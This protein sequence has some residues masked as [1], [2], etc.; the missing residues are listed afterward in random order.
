M[1]LNCRVTRVLRGCVA[2]WLLFPTLSWCASTPL[3]SLESGYRAMYNLDFSSAHG[4]FQ[5]WQADHPQDPLGPVSDAAAYLFSEFERLHILEVE[6]FTDNH[7]FEKREKPVPD[8]AARSAFEADLNKGDQLAVHVLSQSPQNSNALFA[9]ILEN[10]LRG[11]YL[12]LIEK[13][14][15]AGLSYMKTGRAL[16]QQLLSFNPSYYDAYLA[17]GIE[18]YLLG[19]NPAPVRWLLRMTGAQTDKTEGIS[20]LHLTAEKGRLLAPFARLLLAVAAL[21]DNDRGTAKNILVSL[22]QEFPQNSL[23]R[24]ELSRLQ[25]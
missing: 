12:A 3:P 4:I 11:D 10:G 6:L 16:A 13:R 5:Q 9:R 23:Y 21:R 18:N 20:K 19:I 1:N 24:K 22:S 2:A 25:P 17:V 8:P 14:N 7:K 15:L